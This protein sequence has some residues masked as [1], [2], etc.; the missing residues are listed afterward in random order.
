MPQAG[1]Y[2]TTRAG[3]LARLVTQKIANE[4]LDP[5]V[6]SLYNSL[7]W[8]YENSTDFPANYDWLT[9]PISKKINGHDD[10]FSQTYVSTAHLICL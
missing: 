6:L 5:D 7:G 3:P 2:T 4:N 9:P 1:L 10:A 8:A